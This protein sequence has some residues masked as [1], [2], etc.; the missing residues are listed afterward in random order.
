VNRR[1]PILERPEAAPLTARLGNCPEAIAIKTLEATTQLRDGKLDMDQR[2]IPRMNRQKR[3]VPYAQRRLEGRTDSD[4]FFSSI[5]SVRGFKCVQLFVHL[6]TQYLWIG[7]L[8]REKDNHGAYQDF[9]REVG[10][11]NVLLTDNAKSQVGNKWKEISRSNLTQHKCS[12]PDKQ[13]QNQSERKIGDVKRRTAYTLFASQ[14]PIIFWC[15]CLQFVVYCLNLT[16]RRRL[17]WRTSTEALTGYTPDISHL[18]FAFWEKAWYY[19]YNHRFPESPWKPC[20]F[21]GLADHQGDQFTYKVWTITDLATEKWEGG[22]DLTRDIVIP[23][24]SNTPPPAT[25]LFSVESYDALQFESGQQ[26]NQRKTSKSRSKAH[27][28]HKADDAARP[29]NNGRAQKKPRKWEARVNDDLTLCTADM[30]EDEDDYNTTDDP[31]E[32]L[33]RP[34]APPVPTTVSVPIHREGRG[35]EEDARYF[36]D[37]PMA[38]LDFG[39]PARAEEIYNEFGPDKPTHGMIDICSHRWRDGRIELQI[40][41]D[42]NESTWET[43]DNMREDHPRATADYIVSNNVSR[44][45]SRDPI[46]N[47]ARKVVRDTRRALRRIIKLYDFELDESDRIYRVRRRVRGSKKKKRIDRSKK[48]FKY[49]L[50]VPRDAKRALEID[51]ENGNHLWEESMDAEINSLLDYG[52]FEFH[53]AGSAPPDDEYQKTTLRCIFAIKHDLRRKSR[54]VAGGHLLD[55]PTDVQ[56]YSSQVKPISVKLVSVIADKMGLKQLCGD[57]SNA[58]VNAESSQ[59]AYVPKAGYEFGSRK[60]MMIVIVKALY[61]LSAS[62]ADWH[63]HFSNSLRSYG[64]E[65]TRYDKDV[66]IRLSEDKTHY[67][68]ICTY[69]DDFMI[70]SKQPEAIMEL[71]KKEYSVKGEGPPLYYLGNDYKMHKGRSAIGCKK[72]IT[73]AIRRIEAITKTPIKRQSTPLPTGDH[74]ELD[75]SEFLDNDGHRYYQ[76]LIGMLNWIVG[77]GRFDIAHATTSLARFSSCPRK[78]HLDRALRVFGYLKKYPNKRILVDSRDPII[79]GGDEVKAEQLAASFREEY[80][81]AVEE[82]DCNLPVPLVG[83]LAITTFVDSD[84]AHDKVTRR[85]ITGIIILVGR[86]PV[87]YHSKR[88]G[89]VETS[90]YSAEFMAMRTAVEEIVSIRYMLRCLGV[91]VDNATHVYGDNLGVIQNATI[92]DSL[93]KK[94]HVAISYHRVRESVASSVIFPIKI[95]SQDNFSDCLTKSLPIGDHNRLVN[96]LFYG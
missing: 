58:Y 82:I 43:F 46:M 41:W 22:R 20:K 30:T 31:T 87:V 61:G 72:Y 21:I 63:R 50:E 60:G 80:P 81:D 35:E 24:L 84:H 37:N 65:P 76:M 32:H 4:T 55:V 14:A 75:T 51:K 52:C 78:C 16:A 49:G 18:K 69:V 73:E 93:L 64:F 70:A 29:G 12:A 77:I 5:K 74:P 13:N 1:N 40:N 7:L 19:D 34:F 17:N 68:Y 6:I 94:K 53:P 54:L 38:D 15:Y 26:R 91:H 90:T 42:T 2:E 59:K 27:R 3:G 89:A 56:I 67:E 66:W 88:Q 95:R 9:I 96:G 25:K 71:I 83:E 62:G 36:D 8:R 23:R 39:D 44:K 45:K 28:K 11:P 47:W 79:T 33:I 10:T 86:T 57:V 85:S 92:K 48:E